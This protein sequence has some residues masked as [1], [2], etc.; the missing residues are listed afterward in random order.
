ML[1]QQQDME[2]TQQQNIFNEPE[3]TKYVWISLLLSIILQCLVFLLLAFSLETM[4]AEQLA[5]GNKPDSRKDI[6]LTLVDEDEHY[7]PPF[8]EAN[9]DAHEN[10]PDKPLYISSKDQQA[11]QLEEKNDGKSDE[12]TVDGELEDLNKILPSDLPQEPQPFLP[13]Q[14]AHVI[15]TDDANLS[16]QSTPSMEPNDSG[17]PHATSPEKPAETPEFLQN[18]PANDNDEG[19]DLPIIKNS[20]GNAI[21]EQQQRTISLNTPGETGP[22]NASE[23]T[24]QSKPVQLPRPKVDPNLIAGAARKVSGKAS[25]LGYIGISS[26]FSE[27]GDYE[28]KMFEAISSQWHMLA[29]N[30]N[31]STDDIGSDIAIIFTLKPDGNIESVKIVESSASK[32][33]TLICED[34]IRSRA[35]YG[36]WTKEMLDVLSAKEEV[37]IVFHYR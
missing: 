37:K 26:R 7:I 27:L 21:E 15:F 20:D 12:P 11:S 31:F 33:A 29:K 13:G 18:K 30:F 10:K 3:Q 19:D 1:P 36:K 14:E 24:Q 4:R 22:D 5:E 34:A 16:E 32:G 2:P 9:P 35:P 28:Q 17:N 23:T 6:A 8:M 25:S